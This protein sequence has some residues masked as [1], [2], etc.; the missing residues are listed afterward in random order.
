MNIIRYFEDYTWIIG[1][2]LIVVGATKIWSDAKGILYAG[3]IIYFVSIIIKSLRKDEF[4][5]I[6]KK[7]DLL[8]NSRK[9]EVK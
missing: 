8:I 1:L 4:E 6:N 7:L 3:I 5:E 9:K 2:S